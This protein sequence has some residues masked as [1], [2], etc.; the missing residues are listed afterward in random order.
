MFQVDNALH[1]ALLAGGIN[2]P[3]PQ[4]D[5][6]IVNKGDLHQSKA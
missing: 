1:K 2:I 5:V 3:F 6:R 4:R